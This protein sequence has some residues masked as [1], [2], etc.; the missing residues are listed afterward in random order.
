MA[1][2]GAL[3]C[4][5]ERSVSINAWN[6]LISCGIRVFWEPSLNLNCNTLQPDTHQY[7]RPA[8]CVIAQQYSPATF[9]FITAKKNLARLSKVLLFVC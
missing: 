2:Y 6:F 4:A 9:S 1:Q 8:A 7:D 5:S 3:E